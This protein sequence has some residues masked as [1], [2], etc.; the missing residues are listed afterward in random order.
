MAGRMRC[1]GRWQGALLMLALAALLAGCALPPLPWQSHS[2][3]PLPD[4]QQIAHIALPGFGT[5]PNLDPISYSAG[6]DLRTRLLI[7]LLYSTLFIFEAGLRPAP[8]LAAS[9]S[10]SADGLRYTFHLRPNARFADGAPITSGD[11]AFSLNR[12]VTDC[13]SYLGFAFAALKDAARAIDPQCAV[14]TLLPSQPHIASLI[15][16]ALLAPDPHTLVIVLAQSDGALLTKLAEP[17]A[18][19]IEPA[20]VQRY[21][22]NWTQHLADGDG[23]GTSGMYRLAMP[24]ARDASGDVRVTLERAS[25]YWGAAPHLRQVVFDLYPVTAL[26]SG[27]VIVDGEGGYGQGQVSGM[28]WRAAPVRAV[29]LL[30]LDPAEPGLRDVRVRQALALAIDKSALATSMGAVATNHLIPPGIAGYPTTLSGPLASAPLAGDVAQ[31]QAL[32]RSYVTDECGGVA[33]ACPRIFFWDVGWSGGEP[34]MAALIDRWKAALPG[35]PI[36][37]TD[38]PDLLP[39]PCCPYHSARPMT[40]NEDYPDPQDWLSYFAQGPIEDWQPIAHDPN[41]DALVMSAEDTRDPAVRLALYY[42]AEEAVINDAVVV[43]IAQLQM[44]WGVKPIVVNFPTTLASPIAPAAW[45][46]IYLTAPA[47]K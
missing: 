28:T 34:Q 37:E 36:I 15:G 24:S 35:L 2:P 16:D 11:V 26:G 23:Q 3:T 47:S 29:A 40:W 19:I 5:P 10:V 39:T 31:A 9:Y 12:V 44:S 30:I 20:V 22:E 4:A 21:G 27:D 43:P 32:L 41:A 33:S 46:R 8:S 14:S 18:G 13:A 6:P 45:A 7:P 1:G 25:H 42:Q 38:P 17:E